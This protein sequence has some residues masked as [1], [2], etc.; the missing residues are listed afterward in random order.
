MTEFANNIININTKFI[1]VVKSG[2]N[3]YSIFYNVNLIEIN[4][5]NVFIPFGTEKFNNKLILNIELLDSNETNNIISKIE[6]IENEISNNFKNL[7][8]MKC[9]KKSKLGYLLR[10]HITNSTKCY[11]LKKDDSKLYI[12]IINTKNSE[13]DIKLKI[14]GIWTTDNNYGLYITIDDININKFN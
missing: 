14:K 7:G 6:S 9:S 10:T 12:D 3:F 4:L 5:K 2:K 8:L 13:C 1:N 11:I